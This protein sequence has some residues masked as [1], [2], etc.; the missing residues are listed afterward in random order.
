M[1]KIKNLL[2]IDDD[3]PTNFLHEIILKDSGLV[4]N[5]SSCTSVDDG[6]AFIKK[7]Y[8]EGNSPE[9][10][11]I[12]INIPA[13]N[14][15][16]FVEE[17]DNLDEAIKSKSIVLMFSTSQNPK[18]V[19]KSESYKTIKDMLIKPLDENI[20]KTLIEKFF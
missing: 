9:L 8:E 3:Y 16:V 5:I 4:E 18:D 17:F 2:L 20:M 12:D 1:K 7:S 11:F 15:F 14:G 13:K 19:K 10:I 6:I